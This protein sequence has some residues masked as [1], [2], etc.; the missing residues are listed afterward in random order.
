MN[1]RLTLNLGLRW[2]LFT[3]YTEQRNRL[4]NFDIATLSMLYAGVNAS[5]TDGLKTQYHNFGPHIGFAFDPAGTGKTVLR[6]GFNM[7]YFPEQT[8]AS[9]FLGQQ[10][11]YAI[12]QNT[13]APS[14]QYATAAALA[15]YPTINQPFIT[16][17]AIQPIST[18]QLISAPGNPSVI[19]QSLQNQ[20]PYYETWNFDIEHQLSDSMLLEV[21]YAGSRGV[22]LMYCYNPQ[23]VE[24]GPSKV[25]ASLRET[26]PQLGSFRN[27]LECDPRNSSNYHGLQAKL[28]KR[29]SNGLQFLLSYTW[30]K[31]LDYGGTAASGGGAVGN[32]QTITDFAAGYGPSGFDV[33]HRFVGS[34]TWALPFGKN[35]TFLKT[36]PLSYVLGGWETGG[37]GT[38]QSGTPFTVTASGCGNNASNCWPDL[39]GN[40]N[41]LQH[42]TYSH[43]FDPTAFRAPVGYRYGDA[44]RG[45]LRNPG[46]YNFDLYAQRNFAIR[47]RAALQ[48][49]LEAFNAF[50]HPNLGF[51]GPVSVNVQNLA[52]SNVAITSLNGDN[53][54]LE[55]AI[56]FTF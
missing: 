39:V 14:T 28:T 54:D 15:N 2:D 49:R 40:P 56:K 16:P 10:F 36:G 44:G 25:S 55:A 52:K 31:S 13:S 4:A 38:V 29:L 32:A 34:W 51:Q 47:E 42:R 30:S 22:H 46:T 20:T 7:S 12:T 37:I 33:T 24:P 45:I 35:R 9:D 21:A 11:P 6:G 27:L 50:N 3:P 53:R 23:E 5:N 8:S 48:L 19:G 17:T 43:W 1:P 26:I 41:D 18:A